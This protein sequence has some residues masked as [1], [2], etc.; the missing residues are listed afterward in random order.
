MSNRQLEKLALFFARYGTSKIP[1]VVTRTAT[2]LM[3]VQFNKQ[4]VDIEKWMREL[5]DKN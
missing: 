5:N 1:E 4:Y 3:L 2:D